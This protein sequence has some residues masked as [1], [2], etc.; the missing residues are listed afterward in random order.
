[1]PGAAGAAVQN[2]LLTRAKIIKGDINRATQYND[3]LECG[4][5]INHLTTTCLMPALIEEWC[6]EE[7]S[8]NVALSPNEKS[9]LCITV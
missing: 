1:M 2:S 8:P 3:N 9:V 7:G 5:L 4:D 6:G